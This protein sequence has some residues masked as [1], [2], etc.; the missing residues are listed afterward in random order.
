MNGTRFDAATRAVAGTRRRVVAGAA[1]LA[2]GGIVRSVGLPSQA[3]T[4]KLKPAYQCPGSPTNFVAENAVG[5]RAHRFTAE[6]SG[7]LRQIKLLVNK[8]DDPNNAGDFVVQL[9]KVI[10]SPNGDPSASP[11]DVLAAVTIA[12]ATVPTGVS[13]L[14]AKFAGTRLEQGT[15]YAVV[16]SRPGS[17]LFAVGILFEATGAS[18]PGQMYA[19]AGGGDFGSLSEHDMVLTVSVR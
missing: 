7:S 13:T 6:R 12:D 19:A 5:R 9:V 14:T 1:T 3:R 17:P 16:V 4:R 15:E 18:C 11:L 2:L 8:P 10:G